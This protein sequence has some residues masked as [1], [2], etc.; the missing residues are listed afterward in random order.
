[1]YQLGLVSVSF[2]QETPETLVRAAKAAGLSCNERG[3]DIHAPSGDEEMLREIVRLQEM[4]GVSCCS[5]GT[6]FRPGK[7]APETFPQYIRAAKLL[8]TDTLRLWCG[9]KGSLEYTPEELETLYADCRRVAEMAEA[10]GVTLCMECHNGTVTDRKEGALALMKAVASESFQ[11][12]WQPNQLRSREENL[13]YARLLAPWTRH[14][15][16]FNWDCPNGGPL[17]KYPLAQA[18]NIWRD[19]LRSFS[20]DRTLLLEFMPDNRLESLAVEAEALKR[21]IK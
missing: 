1:M 9:V 20:G 3:S 13:A 21:I 15:H 19:Y 7:D 18:E 6:Y 2:R 11:M 14:L 4:F 5:Y 10:E 8:G 12:Y 17:K 16:V